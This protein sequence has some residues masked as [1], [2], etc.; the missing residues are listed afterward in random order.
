MLP[1]SFVISLSVSLP[2]K[3]DA[4][5]TAISSSL[6]PSHFDTKTIPTKPK[7]QPAFQKSKENTLSS[8]LFDRNELTLSRQQHQTHY[9]FYKPPS[10]HW[11][12]M[13]TV[14]LINIPLLTANNTFLSIL[15]SHKK[16]FAN[17]L[18]LIIYI[19][20]TY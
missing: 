17:A 12:N 4:N 2:L 1:C 19:L 18:S 9:L 5:I 3:S 8:C 15:S 13:F 14:K 10:R 7:H 11:K 20:P 16:Y 6:T